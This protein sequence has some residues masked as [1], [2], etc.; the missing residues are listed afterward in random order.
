M[1]S[2]SLS[3]PALSVRQPWAELILLGRKTI[4]VRSWTTAYRGMIWLHV[5]KVSDPELERMF[6]LS[7]LFHGGFVGTATIA[8]ILPLDSARWEL[9]QDQ[10]LDHGRFVH[11]RFGWL[12]TVLFVSQSQS[13][14]V[15]SS[16]CFS[17][18]K[19]FRKN[20]MWHAAGIVVCGLLAAP[21][22]LQQRRDD[23]LAGEGEV[24]QAGAERVGDGVA[25]RRQRRAERDLARAER[26][27]AGGP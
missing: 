20:F 16:C 21:L 24:A 1:Q 26:A 15:A 3:I 13:L 23:A 8:S 17:R 27:L 12:L 19:P 11:G 25:D 5:G 4:E 22:C 18:K 14:V 9:W 7:N 6:G 2:V 10:H